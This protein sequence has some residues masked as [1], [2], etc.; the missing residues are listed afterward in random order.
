MNT[1]WEHIAA[2]KRARIDK[3]IPSEWKISVSPQTS[4]FDTPAKSGVLSPQELQITESTA[5]DLVARLGKGELKAVDVTLAF[6]K[7]A[8][9]A[10]QLVSSCT[11]KQLSW[12]KLQYMLI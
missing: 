3:S 8:A 10:H 5:T 2:D 6:C 4:A 1:T 12:T 11:D 7:R 9:L